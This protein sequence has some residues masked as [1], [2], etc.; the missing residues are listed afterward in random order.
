MT[1]MA[2]RPPLP[3]RHG[4]PAFALL[5]ATLAS[6]AAPAAVAATDPPSNA[7]A[8]TVLTTA[9][10]CFSDTVDAF[11]LLIPRKEVAVRPERPGLKVQEVL[12]DAG[13]T[14]TAGQALARL[15]LPEGGATTVQAPTAGLVSA[16]TAVVGAPAS[17]MGEAL[18]TIITGNDF[19]LAVQVPTRDLGKLKVDQPATIHISGIEDL[20]GKVRQIGATVDPNSQLGQAFIAVTSQRPLLVNASARA[21]IKTGESCGVSVPL[22]AILYSSAGTVVQVVRRDRVETRRVEV[23]LMANGRVE[24]REGLAEGETVVAR[25][26]ALLREGD[27]VRPI[28]AEGEKK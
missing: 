28:L 3:R 10:S 15:G 4:R 19:D 14:V 16:A 13:Q 2:A 12:V 25:A 1:R 8:V 27:P 23:G 5:A 26:G 24:I 11:G 22:A 7:A 18:F 6:A 21:S 17:A 9:K 20:E